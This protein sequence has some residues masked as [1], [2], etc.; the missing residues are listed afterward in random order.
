M[1]VDSEKP[2]VV[3]VRSEDDTGV[4]VVAPNIMHDLMFRAPTTSAWQDDKEVPH[5]IIRCTDLVVD[6]SLVHM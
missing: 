4:P 5:V 2:K 3:I 1:A 6:L